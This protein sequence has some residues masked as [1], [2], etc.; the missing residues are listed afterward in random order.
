VLNGLSKCALFDLLCCMFAPLANDGRRSCF[1]VFLAV[2]Y[3]GSASTPGLLY[4]PV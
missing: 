4:Y 2:L 1:K 3:L